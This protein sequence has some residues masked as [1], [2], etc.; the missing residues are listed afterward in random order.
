[1]KARPYGTKVRRGAS[2]VFRGLAFPL[3]FST[4]NGMI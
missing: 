3:L 4:K 1:M 2:F